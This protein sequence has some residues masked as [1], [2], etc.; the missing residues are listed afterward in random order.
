MKKIILLTLAAGLA[1]GPRVSAQSNATLVP[2]VSICTVRD[3]NL[4]A[5]HKL[6]AGTM[7]VIRPGLEANYES[8][9]LNFQ[10]L[11]SFDMQ[12]SNFDALST[13][14][15]RRHADMDLK[16]RTTA[17]ATLGL[18]FRY[19]RTETP[20]ELN[21]DTGILGERRIAERFEIVPS[22]A[23]RSTPRTTINASY[24][25]MTETLVDDIRG[26][27]YVARGG[28]AHDVD[29]LNS[30]TFGYL[31]RRFV[32]VVGT[33]L[34]NAVLVGW[35][36]EVAYG[37]RFN[38]AAGPRL[39]QDRGLQAEIQAG[40]SRNTD[41]LRVAVDY[42]HGEAIIL[43]IHGPVAVDSATAKWTWPLTLRSEIG[44][45]TGIT[46]STTLAD[47]NVRVYRAIMTGA[48]TPNGGP[49]TLS[50]SY[51]AEFQRGLIRESLFID[52]QVM[53]Q[54]FRVNVT[55]APRLSRTF[56]PTGEQPVIRTPGAGR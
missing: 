23:Y 2:S 20:G 27:L 26:T 43:G 47:K 31:G 7:T 42:W 14:D 55:I 50:A 4:F 39:T 8:P 29:S 51:G 49:Y 37:T 34:S 6:E 10:S 5:T 19:D 3:D 25:A 56:R 1:V 24:S 40:F 54:T 18:G 41:R 17:A 53:R 15:A 11:F 38:L 45:H 30:V 48:W 22:I 9:T 21:L 16:H 44:L 35:N 32:D 12:H 46:D 36:R 28:F 13:L 52:E 33:Y